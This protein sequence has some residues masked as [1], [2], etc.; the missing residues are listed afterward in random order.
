MSSL[1]LFAWSTGATD[2][3][4]AQEMISWLLRLELVFVVWSHILNVI[5]TEKKKREGA[6]GKVS[7]MLCI[8]DHSGIQRLKSQSSTAKCYLNMARIMWHDVEG[9]IILL[10]SVIKVYTSFYSYKYSHVLY[11][12]K[13]GSTLLFGCCCFL[14]IWVTHSPKYTLPSPRK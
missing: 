10:V 3:R 9:S 7:L 1:L 6:V 8:L 12:T 11:Y 13:H 4:A 2:T 5:C 14:D